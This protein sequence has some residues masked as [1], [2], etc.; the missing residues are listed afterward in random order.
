MSTL[1]KPLEKRIQE[2]TR[3]IDAQKA[4]LTDYERLLQM[5]LAR[6]HAPADGIRPTAPEPSKSESVNGTGKPQRTLS[7]DVPATGNK[8]AMVSEIVKSY[9]TTGATPKDVDSILTSRKIKRSNNMVYTALS[10]LVSRKK[11]RRLDGRYFATDSKAPTPAKRKISP[12]GIQR[13]KD[14]NKKR[15]AKAKK[16]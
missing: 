15:W 7:S 16:R 6:E 12:E 8:T 5:E 9:G 1:I 14:A 4:E 10:Y 2:I 13:I 11:L 3:S